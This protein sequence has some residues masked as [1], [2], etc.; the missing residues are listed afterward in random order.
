MLTETTFPTE[1]AKPRR[2]SLLPHEHGAWGQLAMPLLTALA[3]GRP[4]A[5]ATLLTAAVVLAFIAHEPLL[6][7]LG[8]RGRR[9]RAEDGA[10]A[11]RWLLGLGGLAAA[12][13]LGGVLLAPPAARLALVLPAAL[14]AAVAVLVR[15]RQEK[16]AIGEI[17]V[18]AA[19]ASAGWAVALAGGAAP[20]AAL[21]A[22]L[23]WILAFAAA[24]LAVQVILVRVRS[25]GAADPGRR[26]AVIAALLAAAAGALSWAGLPVALALAT[27]PTA[28]FSIVICLVRFSPRRLRELGWALVGSSAVT[29]VIL[30]AGLR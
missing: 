1:T 11:V 4:T 6:V 12:T 29:L 22:L 13:G 15:R 8:Q 9:A 16:T 10:R 7:A 14:A 17:V 19:L 27:L 26:H 23:A 5:A 30:V 21:A 24:T 18:A 28:L 3:I 25:K 2:R 20:A